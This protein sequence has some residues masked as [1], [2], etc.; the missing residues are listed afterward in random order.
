LVLEPVAAHTRLPELLAACEQRACTE[1]V[2]ALATGEVSLRP[3]QH[4]GVPRLDEHQLSTHFGPPARLIL[5]GAGDLSFY[6][7]QMA[8][9]LGFELIVCDP[10]PEQRASWALP[11]VSVSHEMPDDL[12]QRLRPDARTGVIA[13]THDPKLDDL[14]LMEALESPAFYVGAIGSRAHSLQ[15]RERLRVHFDVSEAA[16]QRLRG[17]A[18]LY[19]GSRTPP[20]IA[21][22]IL[23]EVVAARRCVALPPQ[24][25][26]AEGKALE[27]AQHAGTDALA[28]ALLPP[29]CATL[30]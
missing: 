14:A 5:I 3:G 13:L 6:L 17:P 18:G 7:C 11:G 21:L 12:V 8:Q 26:V 27:E 1:R 16:L 19:I 23:A 28:A 20:E 4:D 24:A 22:S 9:A 10:R 2:L 15:R 29:V 30:P 25:Q